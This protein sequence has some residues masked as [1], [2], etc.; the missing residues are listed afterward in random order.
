MIRSETVSMLR[1]VEIICDRCNRVIPR[2][3]YVE[4]SEVLQLR[5]TGGFGS[6]FGDGTQVELDLCQHC[7]KDILGPWCRIDRNP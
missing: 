5:F 7:V 1:P 4:W 6:L 3:D 2:S